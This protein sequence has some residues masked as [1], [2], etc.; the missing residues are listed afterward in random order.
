MNTFQTELWIYNDSDHN[1]IFVII[2][3]VGGKVM[4]KDVII[5]GGLLIIG[6]ILFIIAIVGETYQSYLCI[7]GGGFTGVAI[8]AF[9]RAMKQ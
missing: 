8:A 5:A 3:D 1:H 9:Y 2:L 6:L 4:R 7:T